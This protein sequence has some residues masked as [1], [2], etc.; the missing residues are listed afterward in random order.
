[1]EKHVTMNKW[2]TPS[3]IWYTNIYYL[4]TKLGHNRNHYHKRP[5]STH[6][7]LFFSTLY[8]AQNWPYEP[9]AHIL[10]FQSPRQYI[11]AIFKKPM[12]QVHGKT[13]LLMG[14][15][16][17]IKAHGLNPWQIYFINGIQ[18]PYPKPMV[19]T[20]GKLFIKSPS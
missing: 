9:N 1:M 3:P 4:I 18:I 8:K 10:F 11:L 15:N 12:T 20:H 2:S 14:F 6:L 16:P 19:Q 13:I 5:K 7:A 17:I